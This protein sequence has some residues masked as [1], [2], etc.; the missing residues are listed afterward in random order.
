MKQNGSAVRMAMAVLEDLFL[1]RGYQV[2][3]TE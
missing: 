1:Y 3:F 2:V